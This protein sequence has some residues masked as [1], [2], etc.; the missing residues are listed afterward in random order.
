MGSLYEKE[1]LMGLVNDMDKGEV[2]G[3]RLGNGVVEVG[4]CWGVILVIRGI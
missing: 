1:G 4:A 3:G 2:W